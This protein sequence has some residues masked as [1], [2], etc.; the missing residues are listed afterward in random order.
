[1]RAL[2]VDIYRGSNIRNGVEWIESQHEHLAMK[3]AVHPPTGS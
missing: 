3:A 2:W 1:M